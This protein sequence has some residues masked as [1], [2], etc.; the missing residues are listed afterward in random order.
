MTFITQRQ[1]ELIHK[2]ANDVPN[3][4]MFFPTWARRKNPLVARELGEYWRVF[5]PEIR[6]ILICIA[7]Y[8]VILIAT[9]LVPFLYVIP[10]IPSLVSGFIFPAMIVYYGQSL[11]LIL[12]DT[13]KSIAREYEHNTIDVLR[14]TPYTTE[15]II[16]SKVSAGVWRRMDTMSFL[17]LYTAALGMPI[18]ITVYLNMFS[19]EIYSIIPH[20][21]SLVALIAY[22]VRIPLEFIMV[23]AVGVWVGVMVRTRQNAMTASMV[24]M[25]FYFIFLNMLRFIEAGWLLRLTLDA[26]VPLILPVIISWFCIKQA[27][28]ALEN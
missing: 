26:F 2:L 1:R 21:M 16:L 24:V 6:P 23:S 8:T 3:I 22:L 4:D 5:L 14:A 9:I 27:V 18:I 15:E 12:Q 10:V 25:L 11:M 7:V 20:G 28:R 17:L 13:S 19:P